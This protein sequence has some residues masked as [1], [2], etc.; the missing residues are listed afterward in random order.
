M[1][2]HSPRAGRRMKWLAF[3]G[4]LALSHVDVAAAGDRSS[5]IPE[6]ALPRQFE[7][8]D[9]AP[10]PVPR[11]GSTAWWAVYD[12]LELD[13]L[14]T[15]L[16][17]GNA[18]IAKASARLAAARAEVRSGVAAQ[19]PAIGIDGSATHAGGPLVNAAG[20]SGGLFAARVAVGWE[21]DVLGRLAGDRAAE[22]R[23]V[24]AAAALLADVTLLMEAEVARAWYTQGALLTASIEAERAVTLQADALGIVRS[25]HQAGFVSRDRLD[26]EERRLDAARDRALELALARD[27]ARRQLGFLLGETGAVEIVGGRDFAAAAVPTIPAGLPA[28]VLGRRPDIAAAR[29]RLVAADERL[30]SARKGWLPVLGLTASGGGASPSLGQ[31]F[32]NTAGSFG[33]GALLSIPLL[34]FGRQKA[35][36]ARGNAERDLAEAAYRERVVAALRDVNDRL[37]QNETCRARLAS[38]VSAQQAGEEKLARSRVRAASGTIS[39]FDELETQ[40]VVADLKIA[41]AR[42]LGDCLTASVDLQQAIGGGW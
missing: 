21:L 1:I 7:R 4:L 5:P 2:V 13:A 24:D 33:L 16:H 18:G 3:A 15:R 38:A 22:R 36:V 42:V 35:R 32:S 29:H 37:Q 9:P 17:A 8:G 26:A 41:R 25:R 14:I 27:S 34:D 40:L 39:R 19:R 28:D 23:D 10:T 12:D 30:R 31:L 11:A 6:I 20:D